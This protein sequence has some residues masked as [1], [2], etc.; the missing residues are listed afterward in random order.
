MRPGSCADHGGGDTGLA[1]PRTYATW[2]RT[3]DHR[4]MRTR[5]L[6]PVTVAC[7]PCVTGRCA[8]R[9]AA[10]AAENKLVKRHLVLSGGAASLLIL[11]AW[12]CNEHHRWVRHVTNT[13]RDCN[14]NAIPGADNAANTDGQ[15][16]RRH[17]CPRHPRPR[18]APPSHCAASP[19]S[20]RSSSA[21]TEGRCTTS[22]LT[23]E[24]H[25]PARDRARRI[26]RRSPP[27]ELLE[28]RAVC[29]RACSARRDAGTAPRRSH[30]TDTPSTPSS[31]MR[32]REWPMAKGSMPLA[33]VG[34][35]SALPAW[36][37]SSSCIYRVTSRCACVDAS[38]S[39]HATPRSGN[40]DLEL[41]FGRSE[42]ADPLRLL[43]G[44]SDCG[45]RTSANRQHE[46]D[47]RC[48]HK[49]RGRGER[50]VGAHDKR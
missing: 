1:P 21:R 43:D 16:R 32:G 37:S 11:A 10:A 24:W 20:G 2:L 19:V 49:E 25:R 50:M 27:P 9:R 44:R 47:H 6:F 41:R 34:K 39:T 28:P 31:R 29:H 40:A 33:L 13:D 22:W 15:P 14:R 30:I 7:I 42:I 18:Q 4:F 26:G 46:D 38:A 35:W 36:L 48:A 17:L 45:R 5:V 8:G 3:R 23:G 12:F